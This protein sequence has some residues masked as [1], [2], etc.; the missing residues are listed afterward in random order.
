MFNIICLINSQGFTY[1][2]AESEPGFEDEGPE[3]IEYN[4]LQSSS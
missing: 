1:Q 3:E 2:P 4:H